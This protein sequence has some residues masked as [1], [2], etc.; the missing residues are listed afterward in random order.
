MERFK[1]K[2]INYEGV[3]APRAGHIYKHR[4]R[5]I[6]TTRY[7]NVIRTLQ[8]RRD[9]YHK[10]TDTFEEED[11]IG[12]PVRSRD[13]PYGLIRWNT[14]QMMNKALLDFEN[15]TS[16][17]EIYA[18]L[19]G[20]IERLGVPSICSELMTYWNRA[21]SAYFNQRGFEGGRAKTE[22]RAMTPSYLIKNKKIPYSIDTMSR[23]HKKKEEHDVVMLGGMPVEYGRKEA[24]SPLT[25]KCKTTRAK[26][27]KTD[28]ALKLASVTP[29]IMDHLNKLDYAF[30]TAPWQYDY[31]MDRIKHIQ[32]LVLYEALRNMMD[33]PNGATREMAEYLLGYGRIRITEDQAKELD[34]RAATA[35][36]G[37]FYTEMKAN[38]TKKKKPTPEI[39]ASTALPVLEASQ[40]K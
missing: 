24:E 30:V 34:I 33:N 31:V 36:G 4:M 16:D 8:A 28:Y 25:D 18:D 12:A 9:L 1:I 20:Y 21:F 39:A 26:K 2:I 38:L 13:G 37:V 35:P 23:A 10:L 40:Q 29:D 3:R 32:K 7:S 22:G 6:R 27:S 15:G 11:D 5:P 14:I 19:K 17:I